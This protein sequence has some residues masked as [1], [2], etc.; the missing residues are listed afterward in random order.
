MSVAGRFRETIF[1]C[2]AHHKL[3]RRLQAD[4][5]PAGDIE[6]LGARSRPQ[7]RTDRF[8]AMLQGNP[9]SLLIRNF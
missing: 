7:N 8:A 3:D 9:S 4:A 5:M 2:A 1:S 6:R